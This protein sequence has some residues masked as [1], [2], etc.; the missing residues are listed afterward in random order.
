MKYEE[1]DRVFTSEHGRGF[2][3]K[4]DNPKIDDIPYYV[5]LDCEYSISTF[6]GEEELTLEEIYDSPLYKAVYSV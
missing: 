5:V 1:G 4:I 3:S 6:C 2:I